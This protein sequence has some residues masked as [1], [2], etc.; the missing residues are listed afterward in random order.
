MNNTYDCPLCA[1]QYASREEFR[2]HLMVDH[3]KSHVVEVCVDGLASTPL[4]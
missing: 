1:T 3:R 4:A 2:V